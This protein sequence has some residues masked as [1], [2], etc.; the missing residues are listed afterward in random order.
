MCLFAWRKNTAWFCLCGIERGVM[1]NISIGLP[2]HGAI[3]CGVKAN[4]FNRF[5]LAHPLTPWETGF[6]AT[7]NVCS[8]PGFSVSLSGKFERF[9]RKRV[10][11]RFSHFAPDRVAN[12]G[13]LKSNIISSFLFLLIVGKTKGCLYR[14]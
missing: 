1:C 2:I 6:F 14:H 5:G 3:A 13:F 12:G 4:H 10:R 8:F 11:L 9:Y 7:D